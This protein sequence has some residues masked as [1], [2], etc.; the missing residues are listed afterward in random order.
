MMKLPALVSVAL[1]TYNGEKYLAQQLDSILSQTY[2]NLEVIIVDDCST[3]GTFALA[4]QFAA[5]DSRIRCIR[6]TD[7]IGFNKNFEKAIQLAQGDFIAISDQDDIWEPQKIQVLVDGIADNWLIFS[8]SAFIT[9]TGQAAPGTLLNNFKLD[10]LDFRNIL[11]LNYVTGHTCL[12]AR[13]FLQYVVPFPPA[14]YYDWWMGFVALYHHKITYTD[15]ILTRYRIHQRS[16]IQNVMSNEKR[17]FELIDF[18]TTLTMLANF[19]G[20]KN[21]AKKDARLINTLK[22]ACNQKLKRSY[23]MPLVMV[24]YQN[25]HAMFPNNKKRGM[26]SKIGFALRYSRRLN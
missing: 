6:N 16:V 14:G 21:L 26:L 22:K 24:V 3:D 2:A 12:V 25:Y 1:C 23:Y 7:N 4:Q 13:S 20:Y 5:K 19:A 8:N 11:L 15:Q 17:T 18:K 9:E 10:T